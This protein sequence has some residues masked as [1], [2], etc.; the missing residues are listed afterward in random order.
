MVGF[1]ICECMKGE[2]K[3]ITIDDWTLLFELI[4]FA[5]N[6]SYIQKVKENE[7][8]KILSFLDNYSGQFTYEII[9]IEKN[10]S[11]Q[12]LIYREQYP[13]SIHTHKSVIST[14]LLSDFKNWVNFVKEYKTT[15]FDND[16]LLKNYQQ[17]FLNDIDDDSEDEFLDTDTQIKVDNLLEVIEQKLIAMNEDKEDPY[18]EEIKED[19]VKLRVTQTKY[20]KK[21]LKKRVAR[22]LAKMKKGG[23]GLLKE[24]WDAGKKEI[25]KGIINGGLDNIGGYLNSFT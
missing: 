24:F 11:G 20:K 15:V 2:Q 22:I 18:I 1:V 25:Y 16:E 3:K 12:K 10:Q 13:S 23:I 8:E 7:T 14:N 6:D 4:K 5:Q 19:V 21:E 17:E 9:A